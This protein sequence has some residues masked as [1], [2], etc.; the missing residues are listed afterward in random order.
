MEGDFSNTRKN[1][2]RLEIPTNQSS[3]KDKIAVDT[4]SSSQINGQESSSVIGSSI[5]TVS[6]GSGSTYTENLRVNGEIDSSWSTTTGCTD[7]NRQT[8]PTESITF[9]ITHHTH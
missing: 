9:P 4:G 1:L 5:K 2:R 7:G 6:E 3:S 8:L